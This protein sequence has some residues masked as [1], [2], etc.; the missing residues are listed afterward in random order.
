MTED[1]GL[2]CSINIQSPISLTAD[3][4]CKAGDILAVLGPSGAGKSTLLKTLAGLIKPVSG[5]ISVGGKQ[6]SNINSAI[7]LSPQQ[8]HIGYVPQHFGLFEH[9]STIDNILIG[10]KHLPK[11]DRQRQ[12]NKWLH[13]VDLLPQ[14]HKR[15]NQLSGGQRQRV[16]L[17]RALARE[18]SVLLL[19]EPFSAVDNQTREMLHIA[20]LKLKSEIRCPVVM[21]THNHQEAMLL[22][23]NIL[24]VD[25]GKTVQQGT[26]SE[27][28]QSPKSI[29][30]A[31]QLGINNIFPVTVT[32]HNVSQQLT[33]FSLAGSTVCTADILPRT[34]GDTVMCLLPH[35]ANIHRHLDEVESNHTHFEL[36]LISSYE[37]HNRTQILGFI[38]GTPTALR[39]EINR[40]LPSTASSSSIYVSIPAT[41]I[42]LITEFE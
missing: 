3:L 37:L 15:P 24:I 12:A 42:R 19:D 35:D 16:A 10:L 9:L 17:A 40:K 27:L 2:H 33:W 5:I 18:P 36:Q 4:H 22:A 13:L 1:N 8:R 34:I 20:L 32:D 39:L 41:E 6:W 7:H 23:D 11:S 25:A 30:V 14:K 28:L 38:A 29:A 26:V 31:R 21:V